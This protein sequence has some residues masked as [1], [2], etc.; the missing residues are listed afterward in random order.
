MAKS[1][2]E[3]KYEPKKRLTGDLARWAHPDLPPLLELTPLTPASPLLLLP[4]QVE[5]LRHVTYRYGFDDISETLRHLIFHVNF[6]PP[7]TKKIIFR[8]IRCFHCT[9]GNNS[10]THAKVSP[11]S[12]PFVYAFQ[13]VWLEK[14]LVSCGIPSVDKA[15]RIILDYYM[16]LVKSASP[17]EGQASKAT[18]TSV[19]AAGSVTKPDEKG[20]NMEK[21]IYTKNRVHDSRVLL[22]EDRYQAARAGSQPH[23][24]AVKILSDDLQALPEACSAEETLAAMR[25]CQVG[26]GSGSYALALDETAGETRERRAREEEEENTPENAE[27][28]K[29]IEKVLGS[30]MGSKA[31]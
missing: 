31:K 25:T 26:R 10:A 3:L 24:R 9:V 29:L 6:Q 23:K 11:D 15:V 22:A 18:T 14:V 8:S 27:K 2:S 13:R 16:S 4:V 7:E 17:S 12:V 21:Q 30:V 19:S 20:P 1:F 28:R 5:Y